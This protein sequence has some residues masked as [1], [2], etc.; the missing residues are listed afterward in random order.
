MVR[1][2]VIAT[3]RRGAVTPAE[4]L[5]QDG[6][7]AACSTYRLDMSAPLESVVWNQRQLREMQRPKLRQAG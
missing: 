6:Q 1:W 4:P 5:E 7:D 3:T 2:V